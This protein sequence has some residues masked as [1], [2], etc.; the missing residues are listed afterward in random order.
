LK[1]AVKARILSRARELAKTGRFKWWFDVACELKVGP[2]PLAMEAVDSPAI[3][4]EL[5]R[6][7]TD[8]R[9]RMKDSHT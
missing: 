5:D 7:C 2:E 4:S 1:D 6:L 3:Q 9:K 8:A